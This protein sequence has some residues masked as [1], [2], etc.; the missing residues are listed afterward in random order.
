MVD[1]E[2]KAFIWSDREVY[3]IYFSITY[4]VLVD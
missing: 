4:F 2:D 1:E 3:F